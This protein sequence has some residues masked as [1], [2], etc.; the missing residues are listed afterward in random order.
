MVSLNVTD[1]LHANALASS[2]PTGIDLDAPCV[3]P[4]GVWALP[5]HPPVVYFLANGDRVKIGTSTNITGRVSA[6]SLRRSNALLLLDGDHDLEN[7]LHQH[8]EADRIGR[9]EWFVLSPRITAYI[10]QRKRA[11][12]MLRQP[13]LPPEPEGE[14]KAT[15]RTVR[16]IS[17]RRPPTAEDRIL[18]ALQE[19]ADPIGLESIYL[20]KAALT[21]LTDLEGSTLDNNLSRLAKTG[22]IHRPV[23]GGKEIRGMYAHGPRPITPDAQEDED[24]AA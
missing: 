16:T 19:A 11:D 23:Q 1:V 13:T 6:L 22:K 9:T 17:S 2:A 10:A 24:D 5:S 15:A 8:F 20:D 7:V 18:T 3:A 14:Q 12:E 21:E 4:P